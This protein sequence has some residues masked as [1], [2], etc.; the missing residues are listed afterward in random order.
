[1]SAPRHALSVR[2]LLLAAAAPATLSLALAAGPASAANNTP[3]PSVP[4]PASGSNWSNVFIDPSYDPTSTNN[5]IQAT[6]PRA[7]AEWTEFNVT[8]GSTFNV[9]GMSPDWIIVNRVVSVGPSFASDISGNVNATGQF[10]LINPNGIVVSQSG[11]FDVGGLVLSTATGF[12]TSNFLSGGLT[13]SFTGATQPIVVNGTVI[14]NHGVVAL[15]APQVTLGDSNPGS[16]SGTIV[17]GATGEGQVVAIAAQDVSLTFAEDGNQLYQ[18]DGATIDRGVAGSGPGTVGG[19][20]VNTS[21]KLTAGRIFIAAGGESAPVDVL[22]TGSITAT[23]ARQDGQDIVLMTSDLAPV[24]SPQTVADGHVSGGPNGPVHDGAVTSAGGYVLLDPLNINTVFDPSQTTDPSAAPGAGLMVRASGTALLGD[25]INPVGDLDI[26]ATGQI[27]SV[28]F[29]GSLSAVDIALRSPG[30]ITVG[31]LNARDDVVVRGGGVFTAGDINAGVAVLDQD[32]TDPSVSDPTE[33]GERLIASTGPL[34]FVGHDFDLVGHDVEVVAGSIHADTVTASD[35]GASSLSSPL[36]DVRLDAFGTTGALSVGDVTAPRD[37]LLEAYG[38]TAAGALVAGR[39]IAANSNIGSLVF[40]SGDA[41]DDIVLGAGG[42]L[43]VSG[44]L[45]T[46]GQDSSAPNQVGD[47]L[48]LSGPIIAFSPQGPGATG[49]SSF[50]VVGSDIDVLAGSIQ[51]LGSSTAQGPG[52]DV[53]FQA[54]GAIALGDVQASQDVLIDGGPSIVTGTLTAG[55][56]VG[57]RAYS[58]AMTTKAIDAQDDVV[59]RAADG[60]TVNGAITVHGQDSTAADQAGDLLAQESPLNAFSA[61]GPGGSGGTS[62]DVAGSTIDVKAGADILVTGLVDAVGVEPSLNSPNTSDARFQTPGAVTLAGVQAGRD[63]LVDAGGDVTITQTLLAGR[64]VAV[65][66]TGGALDI[67]GDN[68]DAAVRA[69]DD[70]VLRADGDAS[71][72]GRLATYGANDPSTPGQAGDLLAAIDPVTLHGFSFGVAN[73]A[74]IDVLAKGAILIGPNGSGPTDYGSV[75]GGGGS[76]VRLQAGGAVTL[77]DASAEEDILIDAGQAVTV[78]DVLDAGRDVAVRSSG[79]TVGIG[80]VF[81]QDDVVVRAV[82]AVTIAG[83]TTAAGFDSS[84]TGQVGDLL[85]ADDPLNAYSAAGPGQAGGVTFTEAGSDID[86]KA[87]AIVAGDLQTAATDAR[88]QATGGISLAAVSAGRDV[89]IDGGLAVSTGDLTAGRDVAARSYGDAVS[90]GYVDAQDDIVLR[91]G[92]VAAS[93]GGIT[94]AGLTTHGANDASS[95]GQSGD[96][97]FA[98]D[99]TILS[100]PFSVANGSDIDLLSHNGDIAVLDAVDAWGDARL[101]TDRNAAGGDVLTAEVTSETGDVL[102]DGASIGPSIDAPVTLVS[103]GGDVAVRGRTGQVA[104]DSIQAGDD[105][106]IRAGGDVSVA[107]GLTSGGGSDTVGAADRLIASGESPAMSVG[108]AS[109]GLAGADIDVIAGVALSGATTVAAAITVQGPVTAGG[110]GAD[111]RFQAQGAISF[112][113]GSVPVDVVAGQDILIDGALGS[114][115]AVQVTGALS[116][117][118]DIALSARLGSVSLTTADAQDDIVIRAGQQVTATGALTNHGADSAAAGQAGDALAARD[119]LNAFSPSGPGQPG[120][121]AFAMAGSDIDVRAVTILIQGPITAS[122]PGADARL[123]ATGSI[124]L[125]GAAQAGQDL[126]VD[127]GQS[128]TVLGM[129]AGRDIALR[130]YA[131]TLSAGTL[132]AGDDV[133][134]RSGAGG[135]AA[136]GAITTHAGGNDASSPGQAGDLLAA[137][138]PVSLGGAPFSVSG[139]PDVDILAHGGGVDVAGQIHSAGSVAVQTTGAGDVRTGDVLASGG[140]VLLDGGTV[141]R[142]AS[143]SSN[144]LTAA[145][146][147]AVRARAGGLQISS[148]SAGDDVVLRAAGTL[149]VGGALSSGGGADGAGAGDQLAATDPI[150]AYW[151]AS[152]SPI[153]ATGGGDI[154]VRAGGPV[155]LGGAA[156]ANGAGADVRL[157]S[158]AAMSLTSVQLAG[159]GAGGQVLIAATSLSLPG[160]INAPGADLVLFARR[161]TVSGGGFA[162]AVLGGPAGSGDPGFVFDSG[163]ISR[164]SVRSLTLFSGIDPNASAN[165]VVRDVQYSATLRTVRVYAGPGSRIDITGQVSDPVGTDAVFQAGASPGDGSGPSLGQG[166]AAAPVSGAWTPDVIRVSGGLGVGGNALAAVRLEARSIHIA[167]GSDSALSS[168]FETAV[169]SQSPETLPAYAGGATLQIRAGRLDL[170]AADAI[171]ERNLA[172][173]GAAGSGAGLQ[174]GGLTINT[175]G[176]GA[177]PSRISLF[178]ALDSHLAGVLPPPPSDTLIDGIAAAYL[179]SFAPT[180][181]A[182]VGYAAPSTLASYRFN[183][184]IFGGGA[185]CLEQLPGSQGGAGAIGGPSGTTGGADFAGAAAAAAAQAEAESSNEGAPGL[186]NPSVVT[187]AVD[188][189][190][191][192]EEEPVT[193]TGGEITWPAPGAPAERKP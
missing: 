27:S 62:F 139:A 84:A 150:L 130:A 177:T 103:L 60:I 8:A 131:G 15:L 138:D 14:A 3:V 81:A 40:T 153:G 193:N 132:D 52:S 85:A 100:T 43:I 108:G 172:A 97:L 133:V 41:Q 151:S 117:G 140:D 49:G 163:E 61:A 32:P 121:T 51:V 75:F 112:S 74:D 149:N 105:I 67:S 86:I 45:T 160:Q 125:G 88:F 5:S 167:P 2:R 78:N 50:N 89:L 98:V 161:T 33:A 53:R 107:N 94:T 191:P 146:D 90:V 143:A 21:A 154:D 70:I 63:V 137:A 11:V 180:P 115:G 17:E 93:G 47:L 39:D 182:A 129:T 72:T 188:P 28:L 55:Q 1:M 10:W 13:W 91:S 148:A 135:I 145:G 83:Q 92:H 171:L 128:A 109:F 142:D 179:L 6:A 96:L 158:G 165:V 101:Q 9:E 162:P 136:A 22:I 80:S 104:V 119:P 181:G 118:R 175:L 113:G 82:G 127:A 169:Q 87:G 65:R 35:A 44:D 116:A 57:V 184:C 46:H 123:Q 37:I 23:Q 68:A 168:E 25:A 20:S 134:L 12:D 178:G 58:G 79:A 19:V 66:S 77:N 141:Q 166:S 29:K 124:T 24:G 31:D 110:A 190:A 192:V 56:D 73:G 174:L 186:A 71:I 111:A 183:G 159:G 147:V 155:T 126:L 156:V 114:A 164:T 18:L 170:R 185:G 48:A 7:Y 95:P 4:P 64:D 54:P 34:T 16:G 99:P 42:A 122:G 173:S 189:F 176:T 102:L 187:Q 106:A 26:A 38:D 30:S 59:L 157:D 69:G 36:S 76:D 120:G 152:P 144:Q